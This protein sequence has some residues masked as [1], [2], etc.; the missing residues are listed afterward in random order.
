MQFYV[1]IL[2]D[3]L[4][5]TVK[6]LLKLSLLYLLFLTAAPLFAQAYGRIQVPVN[7]SYG[8]KTTAASLFKELTKQTGYQFYYDKAIGDR[9]LDNT[10]NGKK[11]LGAV[12]TALNQDGFHFTVKEKNIAVK[13]ET[14]P[15]HNGSTGRPAAQ[16]QQPG[17]IAGKIV[18]DRGEVLIG[19]SIRVLQTNQAMQ[20][21]V[22][23][24]YA[25]NVM[26]GS[27]TI[28][29][30][31]VAYQ[32]KRV[33]QVDV[34][35][36]GLTALDIVLRPAS[37]TLDQV[38]VTGSFK[39][40]ST[41]GLYAQQKNA[42]NV[43]DGISAEQ[44]ARTPDINIG[45]VLRRVS[46]V[47]T[48]DNKYVVVR[49]LSERYNQAM[50]DGVTLPSTSMNRRNFSFDVLPQEL[51]SS[52][53]VNKTATPDM[54]AEFSG[55]QVSVNTMDIP[56]E[57]FTMIAIGSGF[58]TQSAGKDFLML[59]ER[60]GGDYLGLN[61]S[62]RKQPEGL[63][64]WHW[65]T[66][67]NT[68]P[69]GPDGDY[70]PSMP[71]DLPILPGSDI[72]YTSLDAIAQ[73]RRIDPN[74]LRVNRYKTV[75]FQN[76]R[77]AIGRVYDLNS[78][79]RLGFSGGATYRNQQV[80]VKYNNVRGNY[81]DPTVNYMDSTENGRGTSYRF[82]STVGAALNFGLQGSTFKIALKNMYSRI[83]D[84]NFNEAYR[85][86]YGADNHIKYREQFQDPQVTWVRQH[87]LEGENLLGSS[88]VKMVYAL[89][90]SRIGQQ[91]QDQRRLTYRRTALI[92][93]TEYFQTPNIYMPNRLGSDYDFRLWTD[94]A[95]TDYNWG[96]SFSKDFLLGPNI[97]TLAKIGYSG[98]DKRRSLGQIKV[99]PYTSF[100]DIDNP[101]EGGYWDVLAPDR[102]GA[103][104]GQAYYWPE[105]LNGPTFE[106]TMQTHAP[107]L[108]LDQRFFQK[109]RL[110]YGVRAEHYNLDNRQE[111]YAKKRYGSDYIYY[112]T[113]GE[114]NW[115]LLP[116]ANLSYSLTPQMNI[117]AAYSKT[118]IRPD[119]RETAY[120]G[121]YDYELDA[122]ISGRQL[123]STIIDNVDLRYEW[124]PQAGEIISVS[125]F[126]KKL[127]A[128]I[129]LV[130][131]QNSLY[132][133]QNQHAA[134][135]YGVELE[136]RKSLGFIAD[137]SW[138]HN[139][140]VFGNGTWLHS[141]VEAQSLP[142]P[143]ENFE[144]RRMPA[145][146]R[147]LFGQVPWIVNA[148]ITYQDAI[149]GATASY[150]RSG[151]RTNTINLNPAMVEYE[152]GRNM[153]D[154]QLSAKVWKQKAEIRL[155]A[156]NLL[157]EYMT[158][159]RNIGAYDN[160][161]GENGET[162][163]WKLKE[164]HNTDYQPEKGD[165]ATYRA[166]TGTNITLS[167]TYNF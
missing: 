138:L 70:P 8:Q 166:K 26:P 163:G 140:T 130:L 132:S 1:L 86:S 81:I 25:F 120:F 111:E 22:D 31:Y 2:T 85:V 7:I 147:P 71:D 56:T 54:S 49:G 123:V 19:A 96:V 67:V 10:H 100:S 91:V 159:Y 148:G 151:H 152:N 46:G 60:R 137:R 51:V 158:F 154:V 114:R 146:D 142:L 57:N 50:I 134:V 5:N 153:L 122:N 126:Y 64:S 78:G 119:F 27:Y 9:V 92:G 165:R 124:Y 39:K 42:A 44:I 83:F 101:I 69:L 3:I 74:G 121:F 30:S 40:E 103:A 155:N 53:V 127:D 48:V 11:T 115:R 89:G 156:M 79:L 16:R 14:S 29:V 20:S 15:I 106:G 77:F 129:E 65:H 13:Y 47:T 52:V 162:P 164:G 139:L 118:A 58:N 113:V 43:T 68:P 35:S 128:P 24:S 36:G 61:S 94:V 104:P 107:Y 34:K 141:E 18:D 12:L 110:V 109:F 161:Q 97:N 28:E 133:F 117:R 160:I 62:M 150:N 135:N 149:F 37:S 157:N 80:L 73:S 4:K 90:I 88:G 87:K 125:G 93:Q 82:N 6:H 136:F 75:P 21:S 32:T 108:M 33:T 45:Q 145:L 167:F 102:V 131:T 38:I 144:Q 41:A 98:W 116:S 143:T 112:M 95:E 55:G 84:D 59:G 23:G 63:Q 72:P 76:G 66:N 99:I 105:S 17:R